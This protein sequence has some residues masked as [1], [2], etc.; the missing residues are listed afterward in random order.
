ML[1]NLEYYKNFYYVGT[2]KSFTSAAEQLCISQPAISQSIRQL[3][4]KLN[5][6]L[7]VRNSKGVSLTNEGEVLYQCVKEGMEAFEKGEA[8]LQKYKDFDSGEIRIG[9]SDMTLQFFLLPY[10]EQFHEEYP[11]IKIKVTNAP[12]PETLE[13]LATGKI[14]FGVVSSPFPIKDPFVVEEVM[15]I[16]DTFV[17]GSQM[18]ELAEKE[19]SLE[20]LEQVPVICLE[21]NS[22]TRQYLDSFL[23]EHG[24]TLVPEF[25][26]A[27]SDMIVQFALRNLGI[28]CVMKEF[29]RSEIEKGE[30]FEIN[31]KQ[32]IPPRH[33]SVVYN[34]GGMISLVSKKMLEMILEKK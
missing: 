19:A 14:D 27:T 17:V 25:E 32:S 24:V 5:C 3:E 2:C 16:Q 6:K 1:N 23:L 26:L 8:L 4:N 30:L 11:N 9:A 21:P 29:A 28:G 10:L 22:S 13:N 12:T 31:F 7:F 20:L 33:F 18:K 15:E 34:N